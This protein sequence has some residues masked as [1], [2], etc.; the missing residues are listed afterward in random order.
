MHFASLLP[1]LRDLRAP[2]AGGTLWLLFFWLL[3]TAVV[4][5]PSAV[6][7][8]WPVSAIALAMGEAG[9]FGLGITVAFAAY[10]L[11]IVLV[12]PANDLLDNVLRTRI[13]RRAG[14]TAR[15]RRAV[16]WT[17]DVL[18]RLVGSLAGT[19]AIGA[20]A[21]K[22]SSLSSDFLDREMPRYPV[23]SRRRGL[24]TVRRALKSGPLD[25]AD[26]IG[27][28]AAALSVCVIDEFTYIV[29]RLL[30][31]KPLLH[32]KIDRVKSEGEFRFAVAI[33]ALA[34]V[35]LVAYVLERPVFFLGVIPVMLILRSA[36]R[37]LTSYYGS[38]VDSWASGTVHPPM[39]TEIWHRLQAQFA[40]QGNDA[41]PNDVSRTT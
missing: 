19:R 41:Q 36:L 34:T 17:A 13:A 25:S 22:C 20:V 2:L 6:V 30:V 16:R 24:E 10:L 23:S 38:I 33:P 26:D 35:L 12:D 37:L 40:S 7:A 15:D 28:T 5:D 18:E 11:G 9:P 29:D 39:V 14:R 21:T 27:A 4:D 1:G 31:E 8:A 3:F 32:E